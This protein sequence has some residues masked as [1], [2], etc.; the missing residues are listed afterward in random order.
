M[1]SDLTKFAKLG[2][3]DAVYLVSGQNESLFVHKTSQFWS[4]GKL[5]YSNF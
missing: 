5:A 1:T 2:R 4:Y 3:W